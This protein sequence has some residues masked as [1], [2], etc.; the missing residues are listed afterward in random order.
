[1]EATVTDQ[2]SVAVNVIGLHPPSEEKF[3]PE[4][5]S[6]VIVMEAAGGG[7]GVGGFGGAGSSPPPP[8]HD[9]TNGVSA[10]IRQFA[11]NRGLI[12][13]NMIDWI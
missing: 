4:T 3:N 9:I 11:K 10:K 6:P 1:V 5:A 7:G 2:S 12:N 13:V 8:P